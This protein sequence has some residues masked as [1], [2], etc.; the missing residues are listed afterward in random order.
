MIVNT[1]NVNVTEKLTY[2]EMVDLINTTV[3]NVVNMGYVPYAKDLFLNINIVDA[4]TDFNVDD[5]R[6]VN[7]EDN[8]NAVTNELYEIYIESNLFDFVYSKIDKDQY[9]FIVTSV[10]ELIQ[11]ELYGTNKGSK[12]DELIDTIIG[13]LHKYDEAMESN[14]YD[15][16]LEKIK[17]LDPEKLNLEELT[18]LAKSIKEV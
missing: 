9:A 5:I 14:N 17:L 6:N 1:E 3:L 12:L 18:S 8:S 10:D 11:Y 15:L 16:I 13:L 2:I 7:V 4:Y